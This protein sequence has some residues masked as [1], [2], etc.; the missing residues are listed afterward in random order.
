M[1]KTEEIIGGR[2][3]GIAVPLSYQLEGRLV[4][5]KPYRGKVFAIMNYF[6]IALGLLFLSLVQ[7]SIRLK[8]TS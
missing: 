1:L 7:L 3:M 4:V 8:L 2:V 5:Y 6:Y